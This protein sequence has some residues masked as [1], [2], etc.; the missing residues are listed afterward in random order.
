MKVLAKN[1]DAFHNYEILEKFEAGIELTGH[2]VKSTKKGNI[3]L[4][5][6]KVVFREDQPYLV[7][8]QI[9]SFQ[10]KN[11]PSDF[12]SRRSKKLLLRE[13]E[14]KKLIGKVSSSGLTIVPLRVYVKN[15]LVKVEI[16]LVKRK[17]KKD[18]REEIKKRDK[19]RDVERQFR[20][21]FE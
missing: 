4:G 16:A 15:G 9:S 7:G 5:G 1:K 13:S 18:K 3:S 12:D 19:Q 14:I 10:P 2:E 11:T 6:G 8:V 17:S 20:E 21:R